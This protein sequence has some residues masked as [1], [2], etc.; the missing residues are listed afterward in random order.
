MILRQ[1]NGYLRD[2]YLEYLNEYLS[3]AKFAERHQME[4][5]DMRRLL[6][7]GKRLH[8]EHVRFIKTNM[9]GSKK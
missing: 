2:L 5:E 1:T 4:I 8:E 3:V 7:L 9:K 6:D